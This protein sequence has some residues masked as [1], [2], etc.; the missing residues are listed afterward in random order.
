MNRV[1]WTRF[2]LFVALKAGLYQIHVNV[3]YNL[4]GFYLKVLNI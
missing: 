4:F 3:W 1:K 2:H